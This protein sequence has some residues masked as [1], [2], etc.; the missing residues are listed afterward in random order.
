MFEITV[1]NTPGTKKTINLEEGAV[2]SDL[3]GYIANFTG[4]QVRVNGQTVPNDT[5]L[6]AGDK[7][8][9]TRAPKGA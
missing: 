5:P 8:Q 4:V 7:V 2:L 6:A 9:A 3:D 1:R